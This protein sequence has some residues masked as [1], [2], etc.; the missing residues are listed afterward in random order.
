M[1]EEVLEKGAMDDR[2]VLEENAEESSLPKERGT[3]EM[4]LEV[5][6][7]GERLSLA[8]LGRSKP[9]VRNSVPGERIHG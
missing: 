7:D 8:I 4:A 9:S 5:E 6:A 1:F 2:E 3:A